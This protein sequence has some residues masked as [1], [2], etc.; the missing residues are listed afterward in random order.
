MR[1]DG[2]IVAIVLAAG[3]GSRMNSDIHKQYMSV[4]G[5]PVLYYSLS[6][7]E[8]SSVDEVV[9]VVGQ[10]ETE[11]CRVEIVEKYNFDKVKTVVEGGKER[12]QSVYKGLSAIANCSYV[13][14]HDGA[15]PFVTLDMIDKSIE[16][17]K[18][19]GACVVGMPVKDTIKIANENG[20]CEYTPNRSLTWL[21]QTPQSFEFALIKEAYE[22][23]IKDG[24]FKNGTFFV[25]D[26]AMV[27]ETYMNHSVYLIEGSYE[28]IKITTAEDLK[29]AAIL[30]TE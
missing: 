21:I 18:K 2:K 9:L 30:A 3:Q 12:W 11:Y 14:I 13:L 15:R 19:H 27:V 24:T 17:V 23:L 20:F 1:T 7:F 22:K 26:D 25:T 10:D 8:H 6:T 29:I 5:K 28:N 4:N 16:A